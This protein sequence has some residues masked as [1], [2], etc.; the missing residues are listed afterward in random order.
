[1]QRVYCGESTAPDD[2]PFIIATV[3]KK[4]CVSHDVRFDDFLKEFF[5]TSALQDQRLLSGLMCDSVWEVP[6]FIIWGL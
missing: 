2:V 5:S 1:M 6:G 3:I 4:M